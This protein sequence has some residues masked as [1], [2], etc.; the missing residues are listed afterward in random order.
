M[1]C[2]ACKS[3]AQRPRAK[4]CPF[5]VGDVGRRDGDGVRQALGIDGNVALDPDT[6]LPAS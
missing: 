3:A 4:Q 1:L 5:A 6:F 2:T